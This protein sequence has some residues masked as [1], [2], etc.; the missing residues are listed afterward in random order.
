M[1]R[2]IIV[3][4]PQNFVNSSAQAIGAIIVGGT[5]DGCEGT[6]VYPYHYEDCSGLPFEWTY[7]YDVQIPD[8]TI[9]IPTQQ[10][11]VDCPADAVAA[12]V[13]LQ[14]VFSFCGD[15][16]IPDGPFLNFFNTDTYNGCAGTTSF[17]WTYEDCAED[18]HPFTYTFDIQ[19][20]APVQFGLDVESESVVS[21]YLD[22]TE[23]VLLPGVMDACG[24]VSD[25]PEPIVGGT[26]DGNCGGTV[27]YTYNFTTCN[28]QTFTWVYTYYVVCDPIVLHV[29]LEGAYSIP[30]DSMRTT[31]NNLGTLPGQ[32][33]PVFYI[34]YPAGQPYSGAPWAYNGLP[35]NTGIQWGDFMGQTPYPPDVVDWVLVMIRRNG[36]LPDSTIWTCAGWVHQDGSVTFPENCALPL[37]STTDMYYFVVQHRN[38][39]GILSPADV[40]MPCGTAVLEWDFRNSN[41]Y[42]PLFRFGQKQVEPGVWA[43]FAANGEQISSIQAI[44][45]LDRTLWRTLQGT[46]GYSLGDYELDADTDSAD[47]NVWKNNQ[48]RTT[49]VI[50]Y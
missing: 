37:F 9:L 43:M 24:D 38:H 4:Q 50:F 15:L 6:I 35:T 19:P 20:T 10:S 33:A 1:E 42:Q 49:G 44:N 45:S 26:N 25:A 47:E 46:F 17:T 31:M 32:D 16:L 13:Q 2:W 8:F 39:L 40:D 7:T 27:T 36:I 3:C 18:D 23:P 12:N 41:S 29:W 30:G 5:Y 14:N 21:C 34:D 48:N 22:A 11:V 28:N